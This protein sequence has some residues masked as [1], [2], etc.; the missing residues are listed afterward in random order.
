MIF[1]LDA[2]KEKMERFAKYMDFK[3]LNDN[4]VTKVCDLSQGLIGK[5]RAGKSDLG[6]SAIEKILKKYQDLNRV[7]LLTGEG[8]MLLSDND[9]R[10]AVMGDDVVM[11]PVLSLDARGGFG[12]NAVVDAGE[13]VTASVPFTRD[14][15]RPGDVVITVYGD[16]MTPRYP[17]GSMVLIRQVEHWHEYLELG[18][19]Y[20]IELEDDRRILKT[21]RRAQ[22]PDHYLLESENSSYQPSEVP[23]SFIRRVFRVVASIRREFI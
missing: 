7:W 20:V 12:A 1:Y 4:Q 10:P 19:S 6:A 5:A 15:A 16:S 11:V 2:M 3:G 8:E 22:Q 18:V 21:I 9:D 13:Y 23:R 14:V 17:S